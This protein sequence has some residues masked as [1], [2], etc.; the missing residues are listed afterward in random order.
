MYLTAHVR[1]DD[2]DVGRAHLI[3]SNDRSTQT[4]DPF[5]FATMLWF[6][7]VIDHDFENSNLRHSHLNGA[8]L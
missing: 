7:I 4:V 1:D 5:C 2:N 6:F 3:T 8:D